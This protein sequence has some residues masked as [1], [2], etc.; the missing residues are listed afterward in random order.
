[1]APWFPDM[2]CNFY[3]VKN[4]KIAKNPTTTKAREQNKHRF[5]ILRIL[6]KFDVCLTKFEN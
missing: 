1:V 5:G 2:F 6:E 4:N 3:F